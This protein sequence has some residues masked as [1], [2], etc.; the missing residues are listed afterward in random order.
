L[1]IIT[2]EDIMER[3]S[4]LN[5]LHTSIHMRVN[6]PSGPKK[7]YVNMGFVY[8]FCMLDGFDGSSPEAAIRNAWKTVS[9]PNRRPVFMRF[10]SKPDEPIPGNGP[11]VWVRWSNEKDD[12]EDVEPYQDFASQAS[13]IRTYQEHRWREDHN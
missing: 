12:W 5:R 7:W 6:F 2:I 13:E 3:L 10:F 9:D 4:R 8:C 11:Q 1:G